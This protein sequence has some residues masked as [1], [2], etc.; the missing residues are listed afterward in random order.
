MSNAD[1]RRCL[2]VGIITLDAALAALVR[3][4]GARFRA[5]VEM[6]GSLAEVTAK[7]HLAHLRVLVVDTDSLPISAEDMTV[8]IGNET[9]GPAVLLVGAAEYSTAQAECMP[10]CVKRIATR[11]TGDFAVRRAVEDLLSTV[12]A[13]A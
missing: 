3:D 10:S 11:D 8:R 13:A 2:R 9:L 7:G 4:V 6:F 5:S 1:L 12:S